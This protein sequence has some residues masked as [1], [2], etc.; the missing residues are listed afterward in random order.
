[1]PDRTITIPI[2]G[3]AQQAAFA[4]SSSGSAT[5]ASLVLVIPD[6]MSNADVR[7]GLLLLEEAARRNPSRA[8]GV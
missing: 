6:G 5:S 7:R 4:D 1:M 2:L 8:T 3:E